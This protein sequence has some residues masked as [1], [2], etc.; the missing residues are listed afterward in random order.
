MFIFLTTIFSTFIIS[1]FT[2]PAIFALDINKMAESE[3]EEEKEPDMPELN[4]EFF[5][6]TLEKRFNE[7]LEERGHIEIIPYLHYQGGIFDTFTEYAN[8]SYLPGSDLIN[9]VLVISYGVYPDYPDN[10][11]RH[12]GNPVRGRAMEVLY[13]TLE[14]IVQYHAA[15]NGHPYREDDDPKVLEKYVHEGVIYIPKYLLEDSASTKAPA[16]EQDAKGIINF[17]SDYDKFVDKYYTAYASKTKIAK[18]K[19]ASERETYEAKIKSGK[20]PIKSKDDAIIFYSPEDG[21][22]IVTN[23]SLKGDN[24]YYIVSGKLERVEGKKYIAYSSNL[25]DTAYFAFEMTGKGK[26]YNSDFRIGKYYTVVGKFVESMSYTTVVG[27]T[28]YAAVFT[29]DFVEMQ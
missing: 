7:L 10:Y 6:E 26:T 15:V 11:W 21:S 23:P 1:H 16:T 12:Y 13:S 18:N 4:K 14:H 24:K 3:P 22:P 27:T 19:A 2:A 8:T 5:F 17:I 28:K 9:E 29:A 25:F 20:L